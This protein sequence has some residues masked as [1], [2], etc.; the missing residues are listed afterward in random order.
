M[1]IVLTELSMISLRSGT[2]NSL[3]TKF[4]VSKFALNLLWNLYFESFHR[5]AAAK[6]YDYVERAIS[7]KE[8]DFK[9]E[10]S[11]KDQLFTTRQIMKK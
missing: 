5:Q 10:R 7:E 8:A 6:M 11:T 4:C 9:P 3:K 2:T 1:P